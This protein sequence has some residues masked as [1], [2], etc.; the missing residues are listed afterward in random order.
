MRCR[1]SLKAINP[2]HINTSYCTAVI[3]GL[4][5]RNGL[6]DCIAC[7]HTD[8]Y[9]ANLFYISSSN[10]TT[11]FVCVMKIPL[12]SELLK[13]IPNLQLSVYHIHFNII[14]NGH[15]KYENGRKN[16]ILKYQISVSERKSKPDVRPSK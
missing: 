12:L 5:C 11:L 6:F 16:K 2:G 1:K 3:F 7:K 13:G 15:R 8:A 14:V 9:I 4:Y 10:S